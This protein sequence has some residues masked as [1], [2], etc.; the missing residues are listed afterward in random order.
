ME[1]QGGCAVKT[2]DTNPQNDRIS[3]AAA[4]AQNR[5]AAGKISIR[6]VTKIYDPDGAN[7]LALDRCS[8][9]IEAGELCVIVG[10]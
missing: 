3:T 4:G 5:P 9:E 6:D 1:G 10:P 7:V 8:L 2:H